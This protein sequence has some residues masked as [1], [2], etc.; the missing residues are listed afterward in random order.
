MGISRGSG[1][2][3]VFAPTNNAFTKLST[4]AVEVLHK[5]K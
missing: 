3:T 1:T 5:D 4:G 2:F